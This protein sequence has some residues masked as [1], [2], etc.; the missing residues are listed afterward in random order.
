MPGRPETRTFREWHAACDN[1]A[2]C[3]AVAPSVEDSRGWLLIRS[4]PEPNATPEVMVGV[5]LDDGDQNATTEPI[6]LTIDGRTFRTQRVES[7]DVPAARVVADEALAAVR[8]L[9]AG[10]AARAK[11]G[12]EDVDLS[13]TG[14]AAALLWIDERQERL[15]TTNALIRTGARTPSVRS[16]DLPRVAAA[17]AVSQ[18]GFGDIRQTLPKSLGVLPAV[19][20]CLADS[21]HP[22]VS[23]TTFSA[24]LDA[25]QELWAVPCGSGAYNLSHI[26]YVTGPGGRDPV[27]VRLPQSTRDFTETVV[28][29]RYDAA[30]RV[31]TAFNKGRGI[32]DCG[33][34]QTWVWTGRDF[35]LTLE[36]SMQDCTGLPPDDWPVLWR[37]QID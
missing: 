33:V 9:G 8:A 28:N 11:L 3:T 27:A 30:N 1:G 34:A 21:V 16:P 29:A 12:P 2:A 5:W 17:P 32:G 24:R 19:R 18:A 14:A 26:L 4:S 15:E 7:G 10:R 25:R 23:D 20:A 35:S 22:N 37:A 31:L 6:T 13:L 36:Q